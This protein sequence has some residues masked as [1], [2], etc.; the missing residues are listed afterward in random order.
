[1]GIA[2]LGVLAVFFALH[3]ALP[4]VTLWPAALVSLVA[5]TMMVGHIQGGRRC[6]KRVAE[7]QPDSHE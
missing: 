3:L 1:M 7:S 4:G 2:I 6:S 5:V